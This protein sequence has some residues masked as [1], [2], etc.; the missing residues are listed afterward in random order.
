MERKF[1]KNGM[2]WVIMGDVIEIEA[3]DFVIFYFPS[4]K[5]SSMHDYSVYAIADL[6]GAWIHILNTETYNE[7][8]NLRSSFVK[9]AET[10]VKKYKRDS[11]G[12]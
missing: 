10:L 2:T 5:G 11:N 12:S 3:I 7:A 9:V 8:V 4:H 1:E 6:E